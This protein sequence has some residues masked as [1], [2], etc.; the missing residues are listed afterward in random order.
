MERIKLFKSPQGYRVIPFRVVP[1]DD[2][3]GFH[4]KYPETNFTT[5]WLVRAGP[6]VKTFTFADINDQKLTAHCDKEGFIQSVT[7]EDGSE[8]EEPEIRNNHGNNFWG[9]AYRIKK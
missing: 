4:I 6:K 7:A 5:R 3:P 2:N 1:D 8:V 9:H